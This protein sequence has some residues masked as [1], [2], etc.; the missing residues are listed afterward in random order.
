MQCG[1]TGNHDKKGNNHCGNT[2]N[3]DVNH[4]VLVVFHLQSLLDDGRL[5]V[6]LHPGCDGGSNDPDDHSQ[7]I[8][9]YR[10]VRMDDAMTDFGPVWFA[11][12]GRNH[13]G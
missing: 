7:T 5:H 13:I 3:N 6:K 4:G 12:Y 8:T 9:V 1:G 2:T 10:E 11:Q